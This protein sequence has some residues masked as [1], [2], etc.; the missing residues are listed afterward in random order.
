[1]WAEFLG[2]N[3]YRVVTENRVVAESIL[4]GMI[5]PTNPSSHIEDGRTK[6]QRNNGGGKNAI[7]FGI[8][9]DA[10]FGSKIEKTHWIQHNVDNYS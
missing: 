6:Q 1:V 3:M 4:F 2:K 10:N 5:F 7:I 8:F 9:K